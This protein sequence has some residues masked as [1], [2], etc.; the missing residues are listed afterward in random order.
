MKE[1]PLSKLSRELRKRT[2]KIGLKV[3]P[4]MT[5]SMIDF[6]KFSKSKIIWRN[7]AAICTKKAARTLGKK[8]R[9]CKKK[10]IESFTNS[11][12]LTSNGKD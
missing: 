1:Q 10:Q 6:K 5:D 3:R 12:Q 8:I 11:T 9:N 7:T 2:L 4:E